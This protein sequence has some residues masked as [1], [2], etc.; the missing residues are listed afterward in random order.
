LITILPSTASVQGY[1]RSSGFWN[2][3]GYHDPEWKYFALLFN[4][5]R[6]QKGRFCSSNFGHIRAIIANEN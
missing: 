3:P 4:V 5:S 2:E 6:S 1:L